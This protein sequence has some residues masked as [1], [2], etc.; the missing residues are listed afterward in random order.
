[1]KK[2]EVNYCRVFNIILAVL[3]LALLVTQFIPFWECA[4]CEDGMATISDYIW[5]PSS[6]KDITT[7]MKDVYGNDYEIADIVMTPVL[8]LVTAALSIIFCVV[9]NRSGLIALIPLVGGL[10][11]VIGY[12][13]EPAYQMHSSWIVTLILGIAITVCSLISISDPVIKNIKDQIEKNKAYK[14]A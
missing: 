9:K 7:N 1:M 5:F 12:L 10:A 6:H 8:I 14:E 11:T 3:M 4:D 13:S 2:S